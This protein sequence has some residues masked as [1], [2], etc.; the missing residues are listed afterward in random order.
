MRTRDMAEKDTGVLAE[1]CTDLGYPASRDQILRRFRV[2]ADAE[3]HKLLVVQEDG[4]SVVGWVHAHVP[5]L[6][7]ADSVAEIRG[8]VVDGARTDEGFGR[9]LMTEADVWAKEQGC[10]EVH[11]RCNVTR[12]DGHRFYEVIGY[13]I[14]N[15]SH[16]FCKTL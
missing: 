15:T 10:G 12:K 7:E 1:L 8:L 14:R 5:R 3:D 13:E 9:L 16:V 2:L 4:G 6:L 11:L